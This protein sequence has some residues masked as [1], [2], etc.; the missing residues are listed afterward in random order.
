[1]L[2]EFEIG[3]WQI[4]NGVAEWIEIAAVSVIG[5]ATILAI[6]FAAR[7]ALRESPAAAY[8]TF[9]H[10]IARGLLLGLDLL[11][12]GDVIRTVTLEPTLANIAALGLLV[13]VRTFLSW[14]LVV[15]MESRWPWQ[16]VN[17]HT[18]ET[19]AP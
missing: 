14:S 2:N 16:A 18:A 19:I 8:T 6:V 3:D 17:P 15:E 9:K 4:A 1:M 12:A 11:I 5:V 7:T 10:R 13:L